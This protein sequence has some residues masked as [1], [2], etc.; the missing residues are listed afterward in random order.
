MRRY[1][2]YSGIYFVDL[3]RGLLVDLGFGKFFE[4]FEERFGKALNT[5]L[6]GVIGMFVFVTCVSGIITT[7]ILPIFKKIEE[8][9]NVEFFTKE[10]GALVL[11]IV[12][13]YAALVV[14]NRVVMKVY[15]GP[16]IKEMNRKI[17]THEAKMNTVANKYKI[18][19]SELEQRT[20]EFAAEKEKFEK[21]KSAF[22]KNR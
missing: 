3:T 18:L 13:M 21:E 16:H 15:Y 8:T 7:V 6:I 1:A 5:I 17:Q 10:M 19:A 20:T 9:G 4:L 2:N 12:A 14:F 11:W 22:E